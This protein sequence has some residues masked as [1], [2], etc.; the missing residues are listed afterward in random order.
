MGTNQERRGVIMRNRAG[1]V[2]DNDAAINSSQQHI[3]GGKR[4]NSA[5]R[6][7]SSSKNKEKDVF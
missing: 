4:M 7:R 5:N 3:S 2:W 6:A 1:T